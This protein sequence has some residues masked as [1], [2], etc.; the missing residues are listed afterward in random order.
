MID[1]R[2]EDGSAWKVELLRSLCTDDSVEAILKIPW[3]NNNEEDRLYWRGNNRGIFS[4]R[5]C[6]ALNRRTGEAASNI[7]TRLWKS[8]VY[9]RVKLFLW[10]AISNVLLACA[11]LSSRLGLEE[12]SYVVCGVEVESVMYI[13]KEF[14]GFRAMAFASK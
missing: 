9:E 11:M 14:P 12:S 2:E 3:P 13:F 5:E 6:F 10:R 7:W 4:I 8:K 1:L